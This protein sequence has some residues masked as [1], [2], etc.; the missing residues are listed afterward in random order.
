MKENQTVTVNREFKS[1]VFS[2]LFQDKGRLLSLYNALNHTEYTDPEQLEIVTLEN[3]IYMSMKNDLA[4]VIDLRLYLY[5]HQ[6]TYN[7]NLP[8]RDLFYVADEY[9]RMVAMRSLYSSVRVKIPAPHFLVFYNGREKRPE[10]E[11][12]LLSSLYHTEEQEP[13]LELKVTVLN[14]NPGHHPEL[15]E[16]C[17]TLGEYMQYINLVRSYRNEGL[18]TTEAVYRS[19]DECIQNDVLKEFLLKNKSEAIKMSIY[20]YNE[21]EEKEKMRLAEREYGYE[22]GREEGREVGREEERALIAQKLLKKGES[23][24]T[25]AELLEVSMTELCR[26]L[27]VKQVN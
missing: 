5:E 22:L 14:I 24:E 13:Q 15:L 25:V 18:S 3:A 10:T 6:S 20:E 19:V 2:M 4:F 9:Q 27:G 16:E 1:T 8:L 11:T 17:R 26:M 7:P 12:L 23:M 21:A